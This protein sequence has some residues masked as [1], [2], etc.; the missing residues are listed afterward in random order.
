MIQE[1]GVGY[2]SLKRYRGGRVDMFY[3]FTEG[4]ENSYYYKFYLGKDLIVQCVRKETLDYFEP[5]KVDRYLFNNH[6]IDD[7]VMEQF[8]TIVIRFIVED[9]IEKHFS[10][11]SSSAS[12]VIEP[13]ISIIFTAFFYKL[14]DL[15]MQNE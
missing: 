9:N 12:C 7:I 15:C 14:Q 4:T 3:I 5:M 10:H 13:A 11:P 6:V 2:N 8:T 1:V